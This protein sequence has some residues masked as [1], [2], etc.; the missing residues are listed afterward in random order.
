M[1]GM[2]K[3]IVKKKGL[4][5][6]HLWIFVI[7]FFALF[8]LYNIIFREK[9]T[10]LNVQAERLTIETVSSGVFQDYISVQGVVEPIRTIY[11]D[12]VEGGRVEEVLRDEGSM[13]K[14]GD[15]IIRLSNDNLAL[16]ISNTEAQITRAINESRN[17]RI[18]MQQQ[19]LHAGI[20]IAELRKKSL[21]D[22]RLFKK[23]ETLYKDKFI[24][25]EEFLRS[26]E[27]YETTSELLGL[28][29]ESYKNDSLYQAAYLSSM[30]ESID[31]MSLNLKLTMRRLD[32]LTINAPV[33]GELTSLSPEV[34]EVINYG[35][36][37]GIINILDSYKL[38]VDIDEHYISRIY[39]GLEGE[40]DFAGS[41]YRAKI[42]KIYPEVRAGRF[43]VDMVFKDE[44]PKQI[45]VGQTSRIRLELGE[46]NTT[47]ILPRGSFYQNTGGQW[48]FVVDPSDEFAVKRSISVGRQN[49]R[50]YEVLDGLHEG[51]R[52]IVSGYE[53]FGNADKLVIK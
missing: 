35:N 43:A 37:V 28:Y 40:S 23:N 15:P 8:I 48:I 3:A 25:E 20:R 24:S 52:V 41:S 33:D 21:Q 27:E 7:A 49:P 32:N 17:A 47:L 39:R 9:G 1:N 46:S 19:L 36:R 11:L 51:E 4:Q 14:K 10:R 30:E 45:R 38:R 2:D 44:I 29:L 5:W 22:E 16:D 50:Y 12:A 31:R 42:N 13:L 6:K 34:G 18:S 53:N 26:Q